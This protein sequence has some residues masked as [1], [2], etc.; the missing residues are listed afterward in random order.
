M[1][2]LSGEATVKMFASVLVKGS[3][4]KGKNLL[5][6]GANSFLL[7]KTVFRRNLVRIKANR[8]S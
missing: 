2:T 7:E 8:K 3:T 6:L 4:L 5:L 1:D